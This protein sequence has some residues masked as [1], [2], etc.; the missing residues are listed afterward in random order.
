[1]LDR[2]KDMLDALKKGRKIPEGE[3]EELVDELSSRAKELERECE[4]SYL[5]AIEEKECWKMVSALE[6][7]V[8]DENYIEYD[9]DED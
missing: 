8:G 1:M 3:I 6:E 7:Y 2:A 5:E 9:E 4:L